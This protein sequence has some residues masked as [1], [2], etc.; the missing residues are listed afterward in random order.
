MRILI[1]GFVA[2]VIWSIFSVL[3]YVDKIEPALNEPVAV[4]PI[5]EIQTNVADS[6]MQI[7]V[8]KPNDLT[9]YFEFDGAKFKPDLQTD[10][11]IAEFKIWLDKNPGSMLNI[12]GHTDII[13]TSEYNQILGLKRA[14]IIQK[15][16]ESK[17]FDADKMITDSKGKDQ[18]VADQT[19]EDGRA[20]NRRAVITIKN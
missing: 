15:Y 9:I 20:K 7:T 11:S 19:T 4:Q 8:L 13:G 2:F 6:V 3:L 16:L 12:T 14:Q 5:S 10:N 18:P 17:G 1:F